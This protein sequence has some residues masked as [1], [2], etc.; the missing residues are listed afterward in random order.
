MKN[1]IDIGNKISA[2]KFHTPKM[3][4]LFM[5]D[6]GGNDPQK[7]PSGK[8]KILGGFASFACGAGPVRNN[9]IFGNTKI[10]EICL[11]RETAPEAQA[12]RDL[13]D[14]TFKL[15]F[16]KIENPS[17]P[18][19]RQ[20]FFNENGKTLSPGLR[21]IAAKWATQE[22]TQN[23]KSFISPALWALGSGLLGLGIGRIVG[24]NWWH[25]ACLATVQA[26]IAGTL[27]AIDSY[28]TYQNN[29]SLEAID[30]QFDAE[31][32]ENPYNI[33]I[34]QELHDAWMK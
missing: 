11:A 28:K 18:N 14:F 29:Q 33:K 23:N 12:Y 5:P 7:P 10:S 26:S 1:K 25:G 13:R 19:I 3:F 27:S 21:D 15:S 6:I 2:L 30:K 16:F 9:N 22:K 20:S 4:G 24:R 31:A 34:S 17:K 8:D 32:A